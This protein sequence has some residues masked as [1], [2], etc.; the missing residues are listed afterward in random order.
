M[1]LHRGIELWYRS[2]KLLVLLYFIMF[3][4]ILPWKSQAVGSFRSHIVDV[5]NVDFGHADVF[6]VDYCR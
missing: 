3:L 2:N 5:V 1:V 4:E 6:G